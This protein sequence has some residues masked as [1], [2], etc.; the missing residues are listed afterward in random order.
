MRLE[1]FTTEQLDKVEFEVPRRDG[2][3]YVR[4]RTKKDENIVYSNLMF[5]C[6]RDNGSIDIGSLEE[7]IKDD[8]SL[9]SEI[10]V[11][12]EYVRIP[13]G[14]KIVRVNYNGKKGNGAK[15]RYVFK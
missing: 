4:A 12:C 6:E 14:S 3:I 10:E 5:Y 1:C 9:N 7:M 8:V 13:K 2:N 15:T 11:C